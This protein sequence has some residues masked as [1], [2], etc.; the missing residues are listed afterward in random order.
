VADDVAGVEI[1]DVRNGDIKIARLTSQ[2][3]RR[4]R[5]EIQPD[6]KRKT[7]QED[8]DEKQEQPGSGSLIEGFHRS[9]VRLPR[10][11]RGVL[12]DRSGAGANETP[13]PVPNVNE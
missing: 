8:D 13:A 2:I 6:G 7:R 3:G 5:A 4:D 1:A 10:S 12:L 9:T 11:F